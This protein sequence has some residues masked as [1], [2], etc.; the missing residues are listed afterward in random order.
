MTR[1]P[2]KDKVIVVLP[3]YNADRTLE[4]VYKNI[5]KDIVDVVL[6]VD[7]CSRD[8]T[9]TIAKKLRIKT[10]VHA[11]NMGYGA[12]QKTCYTNALKMGADYIIMLHPDGQYD[13]RDLPKF[14]S[15]LKSRRGDLVLG[16]RFMG[17]KGDETPFYK[18]L[19]IKIITFLFNLVLRIKIS[20]ANSGYRGYSRRLLETIPFM[21]NGNGYIFDP[22]TL[23]QT[24]YLGFRIK[25][26]PIAKKY[27]PERIEPN[28]RKSIE[29]GLENIKLLVQYILHKSNIKKADF[30]T[31]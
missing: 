18:S 21:K 14:I 30:L 6:L 19:S 8:N 1:G 27:N 15:I 29:H 20:E 22:Q 31:I 28:L 13:P 11:K 9:V 25:D 7:D 3:A 23:I 2:K 17:E 16:S 26:V 5:P 12:N 4:T 10:I 24:V